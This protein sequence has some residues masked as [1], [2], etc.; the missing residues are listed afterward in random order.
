M[1]ICAL[2]ASPLSKPDLSRMAKSPNSWGISWSRM[3]AVV[4]MPSRVEERKEEPTCSKGHHQK[5]QQAVDKAVLRR[6]FFGNM[7]LQY[8]SY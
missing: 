6:S 4:V 7:L 1:E 8:Q 5:Q 3:A 2:A